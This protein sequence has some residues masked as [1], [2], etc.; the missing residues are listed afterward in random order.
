MTNIDKGNKI[1]AMLNLAN[2]HSQQIMQDCY[3]KFKNRADM[4]RAEKKGFKNHMKNELINSLAR[5]SVEIQSYC[6][7]KL[8]LHNDLYKVRKDAASKGSEET[9]LSEKKQNLIRSLVEKHLEATYL[10]FLKLDT[11]RRILIEK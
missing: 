2:N 10:T 11:N 9:L 3:R 1:K 7:E 6:L 5:K 4:K 8:I